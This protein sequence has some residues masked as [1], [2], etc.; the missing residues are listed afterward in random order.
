MRS[1]NHCIVLLADILQRK[2]ILQDCLIVS[3]S[4]PRWHRR[5]K[6][7]SEEVRLELKISNRTWIKDFSHW[8]GRESNWMSIEQCNRIVIELC[9]H[10]V[11]TCKITFNIPSRRMKA[12]FSSS[13]NPLVKRSLK[14]RIYTIEQWRIKF[15]M[16]LLWLLLWE[17]QS[18]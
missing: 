11:T 10:R 3:R 14:H 7:M 13:N 2:L 15:A 18:Q 12:A 6:M 5:I 8:E 17:K 1:A 4:Y 16:C 9:S